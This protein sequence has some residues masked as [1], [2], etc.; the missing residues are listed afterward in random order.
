MSEQTMYDK[1]KFDKRLIERHLKGGALEMARITKDE[2][3][4]HLDELPDL[5]SECEPVTV[6]QPIVA[7]N[8][9]PMVDEEAD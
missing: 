1:K 9:E 3:Q 7:D 2:L 5:A 8:S 6:K 4:A